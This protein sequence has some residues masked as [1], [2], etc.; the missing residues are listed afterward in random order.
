M[1]GLGKYMIWVRTVLLQELRERI[2]QMLHSLTY[3]VEY[4][5]MTKDH[6]DLN[7][8]TVQWLNNIEP[9]LETNASM[10][11]AIKFEYEEKLQK[12]I[13]YVNTT[14]DKL[15]PMLGRF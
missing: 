6:M 9:V 10:Y 8:T 7:S 11:E 1:L 14:I 13:T 12:T 5:T 3:L 2:Q 4:G 15:V